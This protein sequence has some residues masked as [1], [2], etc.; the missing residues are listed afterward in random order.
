M[1]LA[2]KNEKPEVGSSSACDHVGKRIFW[3]KDKT[4]EPPLSS[5][6]PVNLIKI[7]YMVE[8]NEHVN[9]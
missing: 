1:N 7:A 9:R 2:G 4:K 5:K 6:S 3:E 8:E